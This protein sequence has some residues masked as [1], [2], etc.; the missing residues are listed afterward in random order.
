MKIFNI[1]KE[2]IIKF[3][4]PTGNPFLIQFDNNLKILNYRYLDSKRARNLYI[5]V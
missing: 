5:N 1:P 2:K 3:E 4:I